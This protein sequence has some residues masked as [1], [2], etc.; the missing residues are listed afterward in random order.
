MG[1]VVDVE[2]DLA[3]ERSRR[4]VRRPILTSMLFVYVVGYMCDVLILCCL[5]VVFG[6]SVG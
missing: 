1:I 3:F 4:V 5:S 6:A 2:D